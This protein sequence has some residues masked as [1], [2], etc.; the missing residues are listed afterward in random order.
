MTEQL[1]E[2]IAAVY[3]G[4]QAECARDVGMS[5]QHVNAMMK[6]R[7]QVSDLLIRLLQE[8]RDNMALRA[9]LR[10]TDNLVGALRDLGALPSNR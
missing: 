8:K 1:S 7:A 10:A 6:G 2:L 4:S 5:A 9:R 3:N